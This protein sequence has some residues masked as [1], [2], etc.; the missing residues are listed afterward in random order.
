MAVKNTKPKR[1]GTTSRYPENYLL[2]TKSLRFAQNFY[3]A[4]LYEYAL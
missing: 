3:E 2:G 1:E 4:A